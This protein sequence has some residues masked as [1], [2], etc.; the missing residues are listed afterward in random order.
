MRSMI[1]A[2]IML[3]LAGNAGAPVEMHLFAKGKQVT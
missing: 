2:G 3:V 1:V